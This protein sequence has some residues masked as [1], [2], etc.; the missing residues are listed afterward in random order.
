MRSAL[1]AAFVSILLAVGA[2]S[3]TA[4][5]HDVLFG[6]IQKIDAAAQ[7]IAVKTKDGAETVFQTT[8]K[9]V[10]QGAQTVTEGANVVVQH[11]SDGAKKVAQS[12]KVTGK[13]V[14][15]TGVGVV[16]KVDQKARTVTMKMADGTEQVFGLAKD[17]VISAGRTVG[18]TA[19]KAGTA[20]TKDT[21]KTGEAVAKAGKTAGEKTTAAAKTTT[22]T[23]RQV[24]TQLAEAAK[25][26]TKVTVY[27]TEEA[28]KKIAHAFQHS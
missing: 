23:A 7:T 15:N 1:A 20:V 12:I 14:V 16:T 3:V 19:E 24:G 11:T 5:Q 2:T 8:E 13:N 25:K 21:E 22:D 17:G 6:T 27:Y 10:K 9:T 18:S 28:G 26:G 4:D